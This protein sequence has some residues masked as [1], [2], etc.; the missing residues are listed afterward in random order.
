MNETWGFADSE[1]IHTTGFPLQVIRKKT[2]NKGVM[3]MNKHWKM[4]IF[5]IY[6]CINMNQYTAR[7]RLIGRPI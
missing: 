5:K 7:S 4:N 6:E 2:V 3:G 1:K